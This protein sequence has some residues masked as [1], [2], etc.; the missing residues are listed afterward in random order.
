M[1]QKLENGGETTEEDMAQLDEVMKQ[2]VSAEAPAHP[3][4]EV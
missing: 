3:M 1:S 2:W 4:L